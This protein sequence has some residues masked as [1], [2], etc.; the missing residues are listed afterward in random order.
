MTTHTVQIPAPCDWI[1]L[2]G[3]H[4]NRYAKARQTKTWRQAA[5][6][7]ARTAHLPV[8]PGL[9]RIVATIHRDH[10]RGQWDATNW[11]PTAKAAV[12]GLRDAGVLL[13]DSNKW[14]VGPDMR[15][16]DPWADAVLTLT[17]T[18]ITEQG[19]AA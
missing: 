3:G 10:N 12:D 18:P 14:V 2:N 13:E 7:H 4:G 11:L 1:T 9:V 19:E 16:G 17:I 6:W 15:A 8:M 5:A